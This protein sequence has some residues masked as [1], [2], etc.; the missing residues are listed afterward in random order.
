MLGEAEINIQLVPIPATVGDVKPIAAPGSAE[1]SVGLWRAMYVKVDP[2]P[3]MPE[4]EI[5][6]FRLL[7]TAILS[8]GTGT[9][10]ACLI[11]D[12]EH[13]GGP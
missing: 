6:E 7:E 5:G 10:C 8:R 12:H 11:L 1:V 2:P 13:A 3:H 4:D 9:V